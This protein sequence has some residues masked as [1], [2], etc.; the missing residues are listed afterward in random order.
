MLCVCWYF[1]KV[2]S[3]LKFSF[4]LMLRKYSLS[5]EQ[6]GQQVTLLPFLHCAGHL[7]YCF[8]LRISGVFC[9]FLP[10]SL[11]SCD[12]ST[13]CPCRKHVPARA[14]TRAEGKYTV[15]ASQPKLVFALLPASLKAFV[16][17]S[18]IFNKFRF[19]FC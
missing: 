4:K 19:F 10:F 16:L 6:T 11:V 5:S 8:Y 9:S 1:L 14:V 15:T 12:A 3:N 18:I 17:Q 7:T 13:N 2:V